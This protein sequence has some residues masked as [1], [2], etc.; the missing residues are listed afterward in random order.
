MTTNIERYRICAFCNGLNLE[1]MKSKDGY[2]HQPTC[3]TL[4]RSAAACDLCEIIVNTLKR[5]IHVQRMATGQIRCISDARHLGPVRLFAAGRHIDYSTGILQRRARSP[6]EDKSLSLSVSVTLGDG[7]ILLGY[8]P[9]CPTFL[10]FADSGSFAESMGVVGLSNSERGVQADPICDFNISRLLRWIDNCENHH[11]A[12]SE[13]SFGVGG[14]VVP[15]RLLDVGL[16][17]QPNIR[18]MPTAGQP[19][20]YAALS[21]CWGAVQVGT[22]T[23]SETVDQMMRGMSLRLLSQTIQD[24]ITVVRKLGIRYLWVDALCIIQGQNHK[25]DWKDEIK[26][27]GQIYRNAYLTIAATSAC[28]ASEGFLTHRNRSGVPVNIKAS[29]NSPWEGTVL[30]R[31]Y[32]L[33]GSSFAEDVESSPLLQR[34][35]VRQERILSRR[36]IDFTSRQMFW[37]CRL[38]RYSEDGQDDAEGGM[39]AAALIHCLGSFSLSLKMAEKEKILI[40]GVFFGEWATLIQEY[41]A[42]Q[43]KYE[44][45]R[46]PALA[47][48]ADIAGRVIPGRYLSGIWAANFSS[49][50]LWSP[51]EYPA[52]LSGV[53]GVPSW[54]WASVIGPIE[55]GGHDPEA[56]RVELL[57]TNVGKSGKMVLRLQARVHRCTVE[58]DKHPPTPPCRSDRKLKDPRVDLP[59]Y[60][61]SLASA[62]GPRLPG[63]IFENTCTF[64]GPRGGQ[65]TFYAIGVQCNTYAGT[66]H[67]CGLLLRTV[68]GEGAGFYERVGRVWSSDSFWYAVRMCKMSLL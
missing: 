42:L 25:M 38:R 52:N 58:F 24:A 10:M 13:N 50:L 30:F 9:E 37:S 63:A 15:R 67:H 65:S 62:V 34:A 41:S 3:E 26:N 32:S 20:R 12:C 64:D 4:I 21:Y 66:D 14:I 53:P 46:L 35:W 44:S 33:I 31:E 68:G 19:L 11:S 39:Q 60:S 48:I 1:D 23:T 6:V 56:S 43:L 51:A 17:G 8:M 59:T 18:L 2:E 40:Q 57:R 5:S 36:T 27:M 29:K 28:S 7:Q 22:I 61:F 45:D 55:A 54:S 49:G 16:P 47:G